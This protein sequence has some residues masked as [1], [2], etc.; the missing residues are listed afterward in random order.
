MLGPDK[1]QAIIKEL[2]S[3]FEKLLNDYVSALEI[4][5]PSHFFKM[6]SIAPR[7]SLL[8]SDQKLGLWIHQEGL[9]TAR[10]ARMEFV[11]G[12]EVRGRD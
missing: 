7:R 12:C 11:R 4:S 1:Q 6:P 9:G 10:Q 8:F 2:R 3:S 5:F